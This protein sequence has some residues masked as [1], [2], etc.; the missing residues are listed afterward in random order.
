MENSLLFIFGE[1][2]PKSL[3]YSTETLARF[4]SNFKKIVK[5]PT[6]IGIRS[7][8]LHNIRTCICIRKIIKMENSL[9]FIF[10]EIWPKSLY[11]STGTLAR[12]L[13]N[14]KK[15]VKNPTLIRI[16]SNILQN[17]RTCICIRKI[18]KM[19]NSLLFI[20]GEIWPKSLYYSTGTLARFLSN[21]KNL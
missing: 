4:L 3:Y 21:F 1:I 20:F 18:I 16:R 6:L 2:R 19:E 17:I 10:G 5:N 13:S 9:L 11:Y 12:F 14:F 8:I 7:N 15:I